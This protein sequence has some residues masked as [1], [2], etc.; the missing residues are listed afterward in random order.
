MLPCRRGS[1]AQQ[2]SAD[3]Q[4]HHLVGAFA[5]SGAPAR[6]AAPGSVDGAS[7]AGSQTP[8]VE[9]QGSR[10]TTSKPA[11]V[12]VALGHRREARG[13]RARRRPTATAARRTIS[14]AAS[15][16]VWIAR[17]R[18]K[19]E[20]LQ[21]GDLALPELPALLHVAD[22]CGPGQ[23]CAPPSRA[24]RDVQPACSSSPAHSDLEARACATRRGL[25]GTRQRSNIT[26]AVGCDCQ[27]SFCSGAP[28]ERPGRPV[29]HQR[30]RTCRCGPPSPV[31]RPSPPGGRTRRRQTMH[32]LDA[33]EHASRSAVAAPL[34]GSRGSPRPS[35]NSARSRQ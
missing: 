31:P 28:N 2:M 15:S 21:I 23:T 25:D 22:R 13:M 24:G 20:R 7:G 26:M 6:R 17:R 18:R 14:R 3:D 4:P 27:P 32:G 8:P 16:S 30:S 10:S 19:A 12:S 1:I 34:R 29:L 33:V 5:G 9:L 11:S 35:P